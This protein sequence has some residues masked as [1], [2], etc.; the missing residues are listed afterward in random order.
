MG[1]E[2]SNIYLKLLEQQSEKVASSPG[3]LSSLTK[4]AIYLLALAMRSS[5]LQENDVKDIIEEK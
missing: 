4:K 2:G 1:T 5:I 3:E